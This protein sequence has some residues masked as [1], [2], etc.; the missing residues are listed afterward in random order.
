MTIRRFSRVVLLSLAI[1]FAAPL[2]SRALYAHPGEA[3]VDAARD[4]ALLSAVFRA[5]PVEPYHRVEV[6]AHPLRPEPALVFPHPEDLASVPTETVAIRRAYIER[7]G[8]KV[9]ASFELFH[10]G[11]GRGGLQRA[12]VPAPSDSLR[13]LCVLLALPRPGGAFFP[14]G[15]DGRARAPAGAVTTRAI[16]ISPKGQFHYDVVAERSSDG[17]WRVVETVRVL[18]MWS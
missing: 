17:G 3:M 11:R 18:E 13:P 6:E 5:L 14:G 7:S 10:C 9:M 4:T 8:W 15:V 2:A 16:T 12:D 1:P